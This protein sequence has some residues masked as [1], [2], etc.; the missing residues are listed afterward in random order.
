[1]RFERR[2]DSHSSSVISSVA[3]IVAKPPALLTSNVDAAPLPHHGLDDGA[4]L[5]GRRRVGAE[6]DGL[7]ARL[8]QALGGGV[9]A[10]SVEVEQATRAPSR[11]K[12]S[13]V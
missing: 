5:R 7:G 8:A 9:G 4:D 10:G 1:V 13:A 12:A 3:R 11:A 2:I 6:R